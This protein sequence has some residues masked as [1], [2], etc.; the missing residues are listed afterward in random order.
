MGKAGR[1]R[2]GGGPGIGGY[3]PC[4]FSHA[5]MSEISVV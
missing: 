4:R 5:S 2:D 3:F 1:D